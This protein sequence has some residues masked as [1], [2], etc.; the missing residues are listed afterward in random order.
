MA[1]VE[2]AV[3][4]RCQNCKPGI[5]T[6][7]LDRDIAE[8]IKGTPVL[9]LPGVKVGFTDPGPIPGPMSEGGGT[10]PNDHS[11]GLYCYARATSP[12]GGA[13]LIKPYTKIFP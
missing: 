10:Y 6:C 12:R 8:L 5:E 7:A 4:R 3:V 11:F 9:E 13:A 2:T 1:K